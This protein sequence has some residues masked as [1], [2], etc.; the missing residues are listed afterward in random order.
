MGIYSLYC[1]IRYDFIEMIINEW[2]AILL[3]T[4]NYE[5]NYSYVTV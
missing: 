5:S 1:A 2:T 4:G 3:Y